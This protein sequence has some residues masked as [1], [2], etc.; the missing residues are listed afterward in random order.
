MAD[1]RTLKVGDRVMCTADARRRWPT[2][3]PDTV[4]TV[5]ELHQTFS[6]VQ[7][8]PSGMWWYPKF[9]LELVPDDTTCT[10]DKCKERKE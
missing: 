8:M 10:C 2:L 1:E 3:A 5:V 7:V 6:D 4:Q 9:L